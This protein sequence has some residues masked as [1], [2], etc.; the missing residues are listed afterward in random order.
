[1]NRFAIIVAALL[2]TVSLAVGAPCGDCGQNSDGNAKFCSQ[3]GSKL[4]V[5]QSEN[6]SGTW[7]MIENGN[8]ASLV[9]RQDGEK[10]SG[11]FIAR[12]GPQRNAIVG[13]VTKSIPQWNVMRIEFTRM[14]EIN[15]YVGYMMTMGE[16]GGAY[17]Y[18]TMAGSFVRRDLGG[19][20]GWY[21]TRASGPA[22]GASSAAAS[23]RAAPI[24]DPVNKEACINNLRIMDAAKEQAAMENG[25][26]SGTPVAYKSE[27]ENSVL[28]YVKGNTKPVCPAGGRVTWNAVGQDPTCSV[29]G[30]TL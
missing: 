13:R 14:G 25:W 17:Q 19:S 28:A 3:C 15:D 10:I 1:M 8:E 23:R 4:P 27:N 6:F 12:N 30:H 2:V 21:A 20:C 24:A 5:A 29:P 9:I 16:E 22:S 26:S 18:R 11:E 7:D